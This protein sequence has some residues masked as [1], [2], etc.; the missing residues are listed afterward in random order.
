MKIIEFTDD[1]SL[2]FK[3]K[4]IGIFMIFGLLWIC[5]FIKAKTNFICMYAAS[6]FYFDSTSEK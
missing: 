4:V 3:I 2:L 6:T 5:T 1:K